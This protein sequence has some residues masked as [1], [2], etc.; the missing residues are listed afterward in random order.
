MEITLTADK[1]TQ[2][3][4]KTVKSI[5]LLDKQEGDLAAIVQPYNKDFHSI[6]WASPGH[7]LLEKKTTPN[8]CF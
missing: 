6:F 4:N 3:E 7:D 5:V 8:L 1:L 2:R